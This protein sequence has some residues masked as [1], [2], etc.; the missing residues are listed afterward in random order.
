MGD[1]LSGQF[2][3][4]PGSLDVGQIVLTEW[5]PVAGL[6]RIH[7]FG[8]IV[9]RVARL[10][11]NKDIIHP[12]EISLILCIEAVNHLYHIGVRDVTKGPPQSMLEKSR[13]TEGEIEPTVPRL[14]IECGHVVGVTIELVRDKRRD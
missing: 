13:S 8:A 7:S 1:K 10:L 2:S 5:K 12:N 3:Q 14:T 9:K 6:E 4:L 11:T